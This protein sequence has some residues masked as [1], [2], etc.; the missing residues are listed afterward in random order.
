MSLDLRLSLAV[1]DRNASLLKC[2]V[3]EPGRVWRPRLT[4]TVPPEV[5][6]CLLHHDVTN[7]VC[8]STDDASLLLDHPRRA[9]LTLIVTEFA[10]TDA[11]AKKISELSDRI[12]V[13]PIID[14]FY[15]AELLSR[16]SV[17]RGSSVSVLIDVNVGS[18]GS[19]V[20]PGYDAQRLADAARKLP[21][22]RVEGITADTAFLE[23][24]SDEERQ[25][26]THTASSAV[27]HTQ[28]L[29]VRDGMPSRTICSRG[30]SVRTLSSAGNIFT[31]LSC[32]SSFYG[33]V[34][35]LKHCDTPGVE[36]AVLLHSHV[37][38]RPTLS[39]AV[40]SGG[41]T[42][43]GMTREL[44]QVVRNPGAVVSAILADVIVLA[45]SCPALDLTIGEA[46]KLI[47]ASAELSLRLNDVKLDTS[48]TE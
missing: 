43:L 8:P 26:A 39:Q 28:T 12:Q 13:L 19:G 30:A 11:R 17:R 10:D 16:A 33:D 37:V 18:N 34:A 41:Y 38:S 46:V 15:H 27:R 35:A 3:E 40:V 6:R 36:P 5:L 23:D 32:Q 47:P 20:R 31:E 2:R 14:H 4:R 1:V 44:P 24:L 9:D 45:L 42:S 25:T 21:G 7:F 22:I 48:A 29:L